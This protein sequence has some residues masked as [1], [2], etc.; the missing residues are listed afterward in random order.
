MVSDSRV[1]SWADMTVIRTPGRGRLDSVLMS[2]ICLFIL[3]NWDL[4]SS[5][6]SGNEKVSIHLNFKHICAGTLINE[7]WILTAAHCIQHSSLSSYKLLIGAH[8]ITHAGLGTNAI[9][10]H[11]AKVVPYDHYWPPNFDIAL[12]K[13][14]VG[15]NLFQ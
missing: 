8:N 15:L 11:I 3:I 12:I 13:L 9:R 4:L 14:K 6:Q 1:A 2:C 7:Q 10:T 5:H